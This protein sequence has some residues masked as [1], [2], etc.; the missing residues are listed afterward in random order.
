MCGH[1]RLSVVSQRCLT[2]SSNSAG[3]E[4]H[5]LSSAAAEVTAW[6]FSVPECWPDLPLEGSGKVWIRILGSPLWVSASL[7]PLSISGCSDKPDFRPPAHQKRRLISAWVACIPVPLHELVS[8]FEE[9]ATEMCT[10]TSLVHFFP[11]AACLASAYSESL[12][13][14]LKQCFF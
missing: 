9:K 6:P 8:F 7:A 4:C 1:S 2:H 10:S 14:A 5:T 3:L 12:S 11:G 13:S